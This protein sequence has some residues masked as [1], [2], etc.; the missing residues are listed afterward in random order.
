[1]R[2]TLSLLFFMLI[3]SLC[4]YLS[5]TKC[6]A[7]V[8][9]SG[10]FQTDNRLYLDGNGRYSWEE[11]RLDLKAEAQSVRTRFYSDLW[12]R[13]F[14]FPSP[15]RT[16]DLLREETLSPV[17]L[18]LREAYLDLYDFIWENLDLRIG[19]QRIPWGTGDMINPTDNLNPKD[20][21]DM[22][23]F[24]R[25]LSSD[26][27]QATYYLG[28]FSVTG[29][30]I[31]V[32]A[33][34]LLPADQWSTPDPVSFSPGIQIAEV[35][36]KISLPENKL[37]E[38]IIGIKLS[39]YLFG[40][41]LSLSYLYGRDDLPVVGKV[42][43]VNPEMSDSGF[44]IDMEMELIYPRIQV[45]GFDLAGAVGAVGVWGEAAIFYPEKVK[46]VI[47]L[48][49]LGKLNQELPI[50]SDSYVKYLVGMDY[51]FKNGLYLNNQ[52][53]HGFPQEREI[54]KLEDYAALYPA[55][56]GGELEDYFILSLE[57]P[58]KD[59]K[60]KFPIA[61][62]LEVADFRNLKNNYAVVLSSGLIY[63]PATNTEITLTW[64]LIEG[65]A[66]TTFGQF[67]DRDQL[68]LKIRYSF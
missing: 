34:A 48:T 27:I 11:Y 55:G 5:A 12:V 60:F 50:F 67:K 40:Y 20:L 57:Y 64:Q 29:V 19:R 10:Y 18:S 38:G 61:C 45:L 33:P 35:R 14:G 39:H 47:D 59:G 37:R 21:E 52:Y 32:F 51:T 16:A 9:W 56:A 49:N 24:G 26:A 7:E 25:H 58:T 62:C 30:Y 66:T 42:A 54:K 65:C 28:D 46:T 3:F 63:Y 8:G 13:S 23:D 17:S 4:F 53:A 31:P 44:K 43:F 41:D 2:K 36:E 68:S 15:E 6:A 1:M 22:M